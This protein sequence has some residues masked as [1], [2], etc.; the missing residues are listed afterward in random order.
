MGLVG[1]LFVRLLLPCSALLGGW[2]RRHRWRSAGLL[3][4]AFALVALLSGGFSLN[5]GSLAL[6]PA[7]AGNPTALPWAGLPRLV[8]PLLSIS[9]GAPGG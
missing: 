7:L 8:G 5:D 6:G 3:A 4:L 1:V 9:F 2:L